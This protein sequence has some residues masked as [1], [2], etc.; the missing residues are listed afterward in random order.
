MTDQETG[1]VALDMY[2]APHARY[3]SRAMLQRGYAQYLRAYE[4][5][6]LEAM[7]RA[8]GVSVA[9][10]DTQLSHL[11]AKGLLPAKLDAVAGVVVT[12]VP[13]SKLA[14]YSDV[15]KKGDVLLNR[16]QK[17]SRVLQY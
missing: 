6:T 16:V 10:L 17:L 13:D 14:Q 4:S 3:Y 1:L 9:F 15:V 2:L 8:F 12:N 5:V 11:I 7:A